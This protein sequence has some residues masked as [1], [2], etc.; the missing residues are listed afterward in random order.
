MEFYADLHIHSKYSRATSKQC[1][2][3][4]LALWA[5]KKGLSLVA[6]GDFT[7]PAWREE[8]REQLVEAEPGLFRLNDA[9]QD[10]VTAELPPSCRSITRFMLSVEI[11]TIY[12]AG[13]R[14]RKVHHVIYA[15]DFEQAEA[16]VTQLDRIGNL[17]SDGRPIL[18][19]DSRDLL[20]MVLQSGDGCHLVPAHVWT[21]WFA[22]LGSKSG[23]DA[24]D[25][26]YRDLAHHIDAVETGLSSDPPMNW[27]VASL[28]RFRLLS[29]SD[30]HSPQV[31]GRNCNR[32][33]TD[34]DY[35]AVHRALASGDGYV[36]TVDL[37]PEEG[38]YHADGH[39]KCDIRLEPR[40]TIALDGRCP[41][42]GKPVTVGV[43][44]RVELLADR[45]QH[46][47]PPATAGE[48][49]YLIPLPEILSELLGVG[50]KSKKVTTV[51]ERL[52]RE[53]GPELPL[54]IRTP[55]EELRRTDTLLLADAIERLR[56]GRVVREAG[57]DGEYGAIRLFDEDELEAATGSGLLFDLPAKRRKKAAKRTAT[58]A[59]PR[60]VVIP[61]PKPDPV[62]APATAPAERGPASI[63]E[64]LDPDQ[65][66]AAEIIAG[67]LLVV[68][69][70]G[71]GKTRTLTHRVAH[72]VDD[73]GVPPDHC[74]AITFTRR[75][76]TE[77]RD[78]LD[79][80]VPAA[81]G[82]IGVRTFHGLGLAILREHPEQV[83]L[84]P[85]FTI[86]DE[87]GQQSLLAE[88]AGVSDARAS[89]L[90]HAVSRARRSGEADED[91]PLEAYAAARLA[92]NAVDFDDLVALAVQRLTDHPDVAEAWRR[93]HPHLSVDEYQDV[94]EAQVQLVRLLA[95]TDGS[96]CAIGDPDQAIYGFRGADVRFFDSFERDF[97]GTRVVHL[98]RNYRS[99]STIVTAASQMIAAD[100]HVDRRV[101]AMIDDPERVAI[102]EAPTEAAQAEFVVATVEKL[103]G[104]HSFFSLD[105]GRG[106]EAELADLSFSDIAVLTRTEAQ[107]APVVEAL[108][109]S[110]MPFQQRSHQRLCD[111]PGVAALAAA[112]ADGSGPLDA[113]LKQAA[114]TLAAD[115]DSAPALELLLPLARE[116]GEDDARF[117]T[118]LAL[119]AAVDTWDPRAD[120]IALLTL[121]AAKGLEF[122]V[123]FLLG[124]SDGLLPL[125]FG[126]RDVDVDEERRLFYV[127]MTRAERRLLLCRARRQRHLGR[128]GEL[129][130]SPFLRDIERRLLQRREA[131]GRRKP[132]AKDDQLKLF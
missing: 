52:L 20:E 9:L 108:A 113:R 75:A 51:Y 34:L 4:H 29:N 8:L 110:G 33:D 60:E 13:D 35:F 89:R 61:D 72:L 56:D 42:C 85:G 87:A 6:T 120:R 3:P 70:P 105:S 93:R 132:K 31:L 90:V 117:A 106:D 15:P 46:E 67:P 98:A 91:L 124:C 59:P 26:C 58:K 23:F 32:L 40:Q 50:P 109:R 43:V 95:P 41:E 127:G 122:P 65:R 78:R 38:K 5:A 24:I 128:V 96:L 11:S 76:A 94:D 68:A 99:G 126:D 30:A 14:T 53:L 37:Y 2:L 121:H 119:G 100:D 101:Q 88:V 79:A 86:L 17:H 22:A 80:L 57:Y 27:R 74:L 36:G 55:L 21:P 125:R 73:L 112:L 44:H 16:L 48:L 123:V 129:D 63:L 62:E 12:K 83:G 19:L 115:P 104:G 45:E 107:A 118:E 81:A 18:G 47:P 131:A 54:L 92:R 39:R 69:G 97:P 114:A 84:Q 10:E 82:R 130:A 28:D 64:R 1:D 71:S 102:H 66:A 49:C 25:E 7:H 116:C 77:M 103:L 111:Q